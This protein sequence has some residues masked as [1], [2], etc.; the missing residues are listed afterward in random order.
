[1]N[2]WSRLAERIPK[3]S[4]LQVIPEIDWADQ[5]PTYKQAEPAIIDAALQRALRRPSGNWYPFA[6]STDVRADRPFGAKVAGLEI[7]AWRD[8]GVDCMW[9]RPPA[10]TWGPTWPPG[11]SI[12]AD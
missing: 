11:R 4:P 5:E 1:M 12:A 9:G 3:D 8:Q 2:L 7:V 6:A 10:H